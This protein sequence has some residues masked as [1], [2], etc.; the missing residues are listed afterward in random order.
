VRPDRLSGASN[1]AEMRVGP[2]CDDAAAIRAPI[3]LEIQAARKAME[4]PRSKTVSPN[5]EVVAFGTD[6]GPLPRIILALLKN[7]LEMNGD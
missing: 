3:T 7:I 4:V 2:Q 6:C 1:P 5:L